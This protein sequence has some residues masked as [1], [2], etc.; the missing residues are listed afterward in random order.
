MVKCLSSLRMLN[1]RGTT[2]STY[3]LQ[4][5]FCSGTGEKG[6]VCTL[7]VCNK[8]ARICEKIEDE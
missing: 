2:D 3:S 7:N 5:M 4:L 6:Y 1:D 8:D